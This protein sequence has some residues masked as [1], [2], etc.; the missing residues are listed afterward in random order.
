M[1][2]YYKALGVA[3]DASASEIKK[4]YRKKALK[5]HPDK[6][7]GDDAAAKS[8]KEISEA[9]EV[10]SDEKKRRI[11]DQYG[12]D[13]V[14]NAAGAGGAHGFGGGFSS[15]EDAL[16]TFMG[17][18]G[19]GGGPGGGGESIFDMFGFGGG[20]G[21]SHAP[22]KGASKKIVLNI[23]FE[24]SILGVRKQVQIMLLKNCDACKGSGAESPSHV[25]RCTQCNGQGQVHQAHGFFSMTVPCP[26]CHGEGT[27]IT[28]YCKKCGG[29]KRIRSKH[30]IEVNIPPGIDEDTHLQLSGR[31]DDG[32]N[33]GPPG[34][35]LV[36]VKI[37]SH[38]LFKREGID[39][40]LELP[41]SF[42]EAALGSTKEIPK[43]AGGQLS[44]K[45][46]EGTQHGKRLRIRGE[47]A[48]DV[49]RAGNKGDLVIKA[50]VE[51]PVGLSPEQKSLLEQFAKLEGTHNSPQKRT[52][53]D[54]IKSIFS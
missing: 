41:L 11:Y 12:A 28:S 9:Y 43:P 27:Q 42:S 16:R 5:F 15:M 31:G 18:F 39:V 37:A 47:G 53:F 2:D 48:P 4:A 45:I 54:K 51:T 23:S 17:A 33:S 49:H 32:E 1:T 44:I 46:P 26:A 30:T 36:Y 14:N 24:E 38:S 29:Q 20:G 25:K 40:I 21:Q 34:D 6:N 22:Q 10:L 50:I 8:F 3:R 7:P 19:G 35:L 13:A 52:F